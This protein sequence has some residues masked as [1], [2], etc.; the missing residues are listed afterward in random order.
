MTE[1]KID[2]NGK[3]T[4]LKKPLFERI[5]THTAR[6]SFVT[7]MKLKGIQDSEIMKMTGHKDGKTLAKYDKETSIQNAV[8]LG[9]KSNFNEVGLR[10][11][12]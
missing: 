7:N 4:T 12:V 6:R 8:K 11:V 9:K 10:K 5:S 2:V 1:K 3:I